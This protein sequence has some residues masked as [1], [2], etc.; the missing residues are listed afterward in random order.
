MFVYLLVFFHR[1]RWEQVTNRKFYVLITLHENTSYLGG[2]DEFYSA[3]KKFIV[4]TYDE[5][6]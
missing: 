4:A 2:Y 3:K 5:F 6:S 1:L